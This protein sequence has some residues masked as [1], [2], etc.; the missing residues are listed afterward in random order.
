MTVDIKSYIILCVYVCNNGGVTALLPR[1]SQR[2]FDSLLKSAVWHLC[3]SPSHFLPRPASSIFVCFHPVTLHILPL[4]CV[5]WMDDCWLKLFKNPT[6]NQ[7]RKCGSAP[8]R[9]K[10]GEGSVSDSSSLTCLGA[11]CLRQR[12]RCRQGGR[13]TA[14]P[15]Y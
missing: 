8:S 3:F 13:Y 14:L 11:V 1:S 15:V 4:I 5:S 10:D 9:R 7:S 12:V 6:T 2:S